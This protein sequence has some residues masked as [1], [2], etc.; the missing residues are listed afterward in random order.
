MEAAKQTVEAAVDQV[1]A[2]FQTHSKALR[3]SLGQGGL[4]PGPATADGLV[5]E[6][7]TPQVQLDVS[8]D[9]Q[10]VKLGNFFRAGQC[11]VS[12]T[13]SFQREVRTSLGRLS[14]WTSLS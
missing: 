8:Y 12:P 1:K 10:D 13:V 3:D 7:F 2:A 9:G 11:K 6:G 14:R 4:V 5:P